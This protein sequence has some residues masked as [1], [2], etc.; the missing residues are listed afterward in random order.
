[1]LSIVLPLCLPVP[2]ALCL[3]LLLIWMFLTQFNFVV[4][5]YELLLSVLVYREV[6]EGVVVDRYRL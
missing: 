2:A 6:S 4:G 5:G 1:M 3:C